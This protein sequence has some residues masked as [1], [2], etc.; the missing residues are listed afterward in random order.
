M[1][2]NNIFKSSFAAVALCASLFTS[3]DTDTPN[4]LQSA[5]SEEIGAYARV[6]EISDDVTANILAPGASSFDVTVEFVD[7]AQGSLVS[8]YKL[9]A[10][11]RDNTIADEFAPDNSITTE[12]LVLSSSDIQPGA[13]YP[14]LSFTVG[15]QAAIDA[16]SLDLAVVEGGDALNYRGEII[17]SDGRIF[18]STNSG[19]SITSELFYNDGFGFASQFVCDLAVPNAGDY[20]LD[21]NDSYGDGWNGGAIKVIVDGVGTDYTLD[22]G[23]A[24][25]HVVNVPDGTASLSFEYVSGDWDSEVTF[26]ITS[27]LGNVLSTEGPSPTIGALTLDLCQE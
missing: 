14:T 10:T 4:E 6:I 27:P 7:E 23:S 19:K 11:F 12:A 22:S 1:K 15:A 18:S 17:L 26:K 5:A 16:L 2:T 3:C 13:K 25:T 21:M 9:Y 8:E 20:V 24:I